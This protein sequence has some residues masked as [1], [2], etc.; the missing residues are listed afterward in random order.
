M[1]E[2]GQTL[3]MEDLYH[4]RTQLKKIDEY[5]VNLKKDYSKIQEHHVVVGSDF[6]LPTV[7]RNFVRKKLYEINMYKSPWSL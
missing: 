6:E 5:F 1:V 3:K 4:H 7:S 2:R